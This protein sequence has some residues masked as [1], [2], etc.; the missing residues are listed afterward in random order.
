MAPEAFAIVP[1]G[2]VIT[3]YGG[4]LRGMI[5]GTLALM[6]TLR[7]GTRL[8]DVQAIE[9][10]PHLEFRGIKFNLPW[11]TYRPSTAL[12]Q[13]TETARDLKYWEAFLDMMVENRFNVV[14]LWNMHPFTFM[15]QPKNFPEASPWSDEEFAKWQ[16]LY[17]E[18]F[19]MAKERALDTYIVHWSIFVSR[20]FAEAHGVAKKN[21]YPHYY[22]EG[23]TSEIVGAISEKALHRYSTS[24][25]IS[26]AS[27]FP[28]AKAWRE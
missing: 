9:E 16:H 28:T 23:D 10:K 14:S 7:G 12:T 26:M 1:E 19:R 25:R 15:V 21:F 27:V 18:I 6:E 2:K 17:R 24:I 20:N 13:H 4:D 11:E 3:I 5:Y 8:Q 22:V